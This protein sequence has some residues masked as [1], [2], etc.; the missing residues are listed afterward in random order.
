MK[1]IE[2]VEVGR[3]GASL[4]PIQMQPFTYSEQLKLPFEAQPTGIKIRGTSECFVPSPECSLS[5]CV[6][7]S[8]RL[9]GTSYM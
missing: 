1:L 4:T 5:L 3:D 8:E 6:H 7:I 2:Q 9:R